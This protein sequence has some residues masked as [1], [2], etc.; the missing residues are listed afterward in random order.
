[1]QGKNRWLDAQIGF[2]N[3]WFLRLTTLA[4]VYIYLFIYLLCSFL[5]W[6]IIA[7]APLYGSF[8]P[9]DEASLNIVWIFSFAVQEEEVTSF[10][11]DFEE[12]K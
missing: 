1:M 6:W 8:P 4:T 12:K 2:S 5:I 9:F 10:M 11:K 3:S 7:V